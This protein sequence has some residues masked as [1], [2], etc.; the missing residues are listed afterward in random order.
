MTFQPRMETEI[1]GIAVRAP[2]RWR[3]WPGAVADLWQADSAAG[4]GGF[5][6]A[7]YPRL[8]VVLERTGGDI[9]LRL[10][11]DGPDIAG[12]PAARHLSYVPAG[13]PL[14]SRTPRALSLT[15]LDLHLDPAMLAERLGPDVDLT[16]PRLRFQDE[17]L[18]A[19][20]RLIAAECAAATPLDDLYGDGLVRA[21]VAAL[22]APR[23]AEATA[24]ARPGPSLSSAQLG[25]VAAFIAAGCAG[26]LRLKDLADLCGLSPSYFSHAYRNAS[27]E[28]PSQA[29]ARAR[30]AQAKRLLAA[31]A[32]P[33][34]AVAAATGFA[35]QAHLTRVFR[36]HCGV[37][38]SAW[39][40]APGRLD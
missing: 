40:R 27:G 5:Y 29:I 6:V 4:G 11:A 28:T 34:S 7:P 35:D 16:V 25:R 22:F 32:M 17:R 15:H 21:L 13:M 14:W 38:P 23:A 18:L 10:S 26:P 30:V 37:T 9:D 33:L 20:A 8:F 19:L 2:L 3:C 36:Q 1:H 31:D 39:R 12:R 24:A